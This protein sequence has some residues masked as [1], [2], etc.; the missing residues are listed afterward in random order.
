MNGC[1][2]YEQSSH[3]FGLQMAYRGT[4]SN[5]PELHLAVCDCPIVGWSKVKP[6]FSKGTVVCTTAAT[7]GAPASSLF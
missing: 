2:Q 3:A 5:S 4:D 1:L 6:S 7:A